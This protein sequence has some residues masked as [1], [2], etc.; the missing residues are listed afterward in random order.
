MNRRLPLH[1]SCTS[2]TVAM[3]ERYFL[4]KSGVKTTRMQGLPGEGHIDIGREVLAREGIVPADDHA[5]YTQMFR[6][7]FVRVV[8]HDDGRV[9]VEYGKPLTKHQKRFLNALED[10]GKKLVYI[11]A[12][13]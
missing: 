13:R 11:S 12:R 5:A 10:Q 1:M 3:P 8:E 2:F 9:E 7:R 6:L 4:N